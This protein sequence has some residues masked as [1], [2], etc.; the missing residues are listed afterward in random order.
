MKDV[1]KM[2]NDEIYLEIYKLTKV[3]EAQNVRYSAEY[4]QGLLDEL[5]LRQLD[6]AA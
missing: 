1:K 6:K 3:Y 4:L 5:E 2:T